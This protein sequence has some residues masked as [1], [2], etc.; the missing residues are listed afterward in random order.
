MLS[1]DRSVGKRIAYL[2][3]QIRLSQEDLA[4]ISG[5]NYKHIGKIEAGLIGTRIPTLVRLAVALDVSLEML[6]A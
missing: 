2:R 5:V 3:K 6:L 1:I 4:K